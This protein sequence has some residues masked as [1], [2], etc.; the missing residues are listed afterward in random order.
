MVNSEIAAIIYGLASAASWGAGDFSGGFATKSGSVLGV[1]FVGYLISVFLL[2]ICA[3]WLGSPLPNMISSTAGA[4]A[5]VA[6]LIGLAALYKGLAMGQMG[7]V[8]PLAAVTTAALPI[9]FGMLLEGSPSGL[10]IIG[11]LIAFIAIWLLSVSGKSQEFQGLQLAL[12]IAAGLF[13]G[14]SLIL[15]DQAAEQSVLWSLVVNRIAGIAVLILLL[16]V[17]RKGQMPLKGTYPIVCLAAVFDTGGYTF[18]ALAANSGRLD[19]AAVLAAMYPAA[20][21][22]LARLLLKERLSGKQWIGVITAFIAITM[23]AA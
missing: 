5:G 19:A 8:A 18:Y 9:L 20:T 12:P 23:I 14:L 4:L 10:H 1:L 15:I 6:G 3:L 11:F 22:M 17:F 21:V 2:S 13:L 7:V 16:L